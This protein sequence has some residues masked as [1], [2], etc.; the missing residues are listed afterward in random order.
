M[1]DYSLYEKAYLPDP[2]FPVRVF[3]NLED[4]SDSGIHN[5]WHE[6]IELLY[7]VKG[8]AIVECNSLPIDVKPGDLIVVNSND[9]HRVQ[10]G[11]DT[12]TYYCIII[13]TSLFQS[14]STD[15]CEVKYIDPIT[16]NLIVF[17][18]KI[19]NDSEVIS[20]IEN[21]I[22][23]NE[24]KD[25]GFELSIKSYMY[26]LLVLLLRNYI[27]KILTPK[28]YGIKVRNLG[29]LNCVLKYIEE[30]YTEKITI[31]QL[32]DMICVSNYYFCHLFKQVTGKTLSEYVNSIRVNAAEV[33]LKSSDMNITEVALTVGFNDINY[34]SRVFKKHKKYPPSKVR[35]TAM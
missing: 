30:N 27:N 9:L 5:H 23:E 31:N 17:K 32:A 6:Q 33:L 12:I 1:R 34:F 13:D 24:K 8:N 26:R 3:C 18:N 10:D 7:F 21:I 16:K 29:K 20:C 14:R 15:A 2:G 35:K 19:C 11:W 22:N 28:E 25:I 4:D